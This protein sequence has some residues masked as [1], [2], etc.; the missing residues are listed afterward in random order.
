MSKMEKV[1]EG[2]SDV[3][4]AFTKNKNKIRC[5]YTVQRDNTIYCNYHAYID[6]DDFVVCPVDPS[7]SVKKE[8]LEQHVKRCNRTLDNKKLEQSEWYNK[9]INVV[10][11]SFD[12]SSV[13]KRL[14][15]I[16]KI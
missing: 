11:P 3:Q 7:H 12:L 15:L 6:T 13:S 8:K 9:D 14:Y 16:Y 4:C 5:K 10:D 2:S 1:V